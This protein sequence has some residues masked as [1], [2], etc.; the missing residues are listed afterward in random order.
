MPCH[1]S[2]GRQ[3]IWEIVRESASMRKIR[4]IFR[5]K[6]VIEKAFMR[7]HTLAA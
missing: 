7:E 3:R 2:P 4:T 1:R 6:L 5:A